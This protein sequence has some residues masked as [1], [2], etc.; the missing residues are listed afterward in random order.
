MIEG[1]IRYLRHAID[2]LEPNES[3]IVIGADK[4]KIILTILENNQSNTDCNI[5][6]SPSDNSAR[7]N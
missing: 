2:T 6:Q 4:A 5:V 1:I 3:K 7:E